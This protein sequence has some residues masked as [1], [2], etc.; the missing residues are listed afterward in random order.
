MKIGTSASF[1]IECHHEP[2]PTEKRWVFG[3]MC[4][5]ASGKKLGDIEEPAC[6]LNV[7]ANH[8]S[9][10]LRRLDTLDESDFYDLSDNSL[11]ELL[12]NALYRDDDRTTAEVA[13]DAEKF[14]KFDFLT[15]GGESF[16]NTK[17]FMAAKQERLRLVF[18]DRDGALS[19]AHFSREEFTTAVNTFLAWLAAETAK[20]GA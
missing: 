8:L 2:I 3:R 6:M 1:A 7:T 20:N 12:D 13:A 16:D 19:S 18:Q 4:I 11:F 10:V 17:S 5:L 15:N 9:S 14:F